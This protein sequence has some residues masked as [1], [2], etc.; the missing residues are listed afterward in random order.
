M[1]KKTEI[2]ILIIILLLSVSGLI[3]TVVSSLKGDFNPINFLSVVL[4][5]VVYG[6]VR[7]LISKIRE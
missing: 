3:F 5:L 2:I 7:A 4:V 1:T 6:T